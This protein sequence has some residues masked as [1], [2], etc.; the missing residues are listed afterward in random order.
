[1]SLRL[2]YADD[3]LS[4]GSAMSVALEFID[5]IVPIETIR[6]RYPGGWEQCLHD[7][8]NLIGGRVWYDDH[9]LR[10]GA[11]NPTDIGRLVDEWTALGFEVT[12][13]RDG[14]VYWQ[15]VCVVQSLLAGPTLPCDWLEMH[16]S[17][18]AAYLA[19]TEP[20]PVIGRKHFRKD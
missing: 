13:S 5:F 9:L 8:R 14:Q 1:M 3:R 16:D 11:M 10:D 2:S 6:R 19:G 20:G 15:D 17:E 4:E 12:A 7:H 18:R